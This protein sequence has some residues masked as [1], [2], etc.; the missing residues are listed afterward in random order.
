MRSLGGPAGHLRP[1]EA[2]IHVELVEADDVVR[3]RGARA[4]ILEEHPAA[5]VRARDMLHKGIARAVEGHD[6]G[7]V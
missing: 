6:G 1:H 5:R 7:I 3:L 4:R 2:L